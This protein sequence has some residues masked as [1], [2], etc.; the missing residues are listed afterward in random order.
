LIRGLGRHK[1][2]K[3]RILKLVLIL[4]VALVVAGKAPGAWACSCAPS[5]GQ[6]NFRRA[7]V[8]FDGKAVA[9]DDPA[10]PG[11]PVSSGRAI[12]WTFDVSGVQKGNASDPQVVE[13]AASGASCGYEFKI[14]TRYQV[15][16]D[17]QDGKLQASLCSGTHVLGAGELA[18]TGSPVI[19]LAMGLLFVTAGLLLRR[20][21]SPAP[22]R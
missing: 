21:I 12:K 9:K 18:A 19:P 8:V 2:A 15:F 16:A 13:S 5:N 4:A 14:G 1:L 22:Q 10:R 6:D 17:K 20:V 7:D 11:E 3:M